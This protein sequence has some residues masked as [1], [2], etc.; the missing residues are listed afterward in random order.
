MDLKYRSDIDG[1]RAIA[2]LPVIFFHTGLAGFSGGFVGVDIFFVISGFLITSIILKEIRD[3]KFS[4]ARFYERRIRRIFPAL[5]PVIAFTLAIG[6]YLFDYRAFMDLGHSITATTLFASNILFW[7]ESGYFATTSLEKPLLHTWSLAVEEQFYILFP[8]M[9]VGINRFFKS[10]YLPWLIGIG[11]ISLLM[12]AWGVYSYSGGA[13]YLMPSRA[14]ELLAGSFVAIGAIPRLG[15]RFLRN[16]LS[17]LGITLIFFSVGF[18]TETTLFPG[19]NAIAPVLG[20]SLIIYSGVGG[21]SA[22]SKLLSL[23]PLVFIGHISYSL[24]LWHW[25]L[26]VFAKY[27][28][29]RELSHIEISGVIFTTFII[30]VL[31]W[32][33]IEQPF[34]GKEPIISDRKPL[35]A[36]SVVVVIISVCIGLAIYIEK[37]FPQRS[38]WNT[39]IM[40]VNDDYD[41]ERKQI[42][43]YEKNA[44]EIHEGKMPLQI[45]ASNNNPI[46]ILWGDSHAAAL[47]PAI[48]EKS[49]QYRVSGFVTFHSS[50]PP[51]I[52]IDRV[53][54]NF[55]EPRFNQSVINFI[56]YHQE[57]KTVILAAYWEEYYTETVNKKLKGVDRTYTITRSNLFTEHLLKT[58]E[59]LLGLGRKVVLVTPVPIYKYDVK[60]IYWWTKRRNEECSELQPTISEYHQKNKEVLGLFR[61]FET[62]PKVKVVS[63]E[64][65]LFDQNGKALIMTN[66]GLLYRDNNHLSTYGAHFVAP[67]F[68]DVFSK[69]NNLQ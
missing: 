32:K 10:S 2:V 45:G 35:F 7:R 57:I 62:H 29:F 64:S 37:G 58:V 33:F 65:M 60:R 59:T 11:F 38:E 30:S 34:R 50:C 43:M 18:Y 66:N 22:I 28:L 15:S 41:L 19:H 8:L 20:A 6:A 13:F 23:S 12:S 24:Y 61:E 25:P 67:V 14:W 40:K 49:S 53:D 5:F 63:P 48:S 44:E 16:L 54:R 1:L 36:L 39:A 42:E 3:D 17:L 69:M 21:S 51:V 26:I 47:I 55:N 31:S 4:V 46:F 68:D 9:L 56:R 27:I 52:G